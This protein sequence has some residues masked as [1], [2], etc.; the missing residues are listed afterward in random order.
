[1]RI[2]RNRAAAA[3]ATAFLATLALTACSAGTEAKSAGAADAPSSAA[4][5]PLNA[6]D[7]SKTLNSGQATGKTDADQ[8]SGPQIVANGESGNRTTGSGSGSR[9][10]TKTGTA[11]RTGTAAATGTRYTTCTGDNTKV[12]V[13]AVSRPINHLL[14]TATNAGSKNC[15]AYSAPL[16][17][18]DEDQAA[19][20]V[21][22]DSRP[23]AVV[24]LAP[25]ESAYASILLSSGDGS[26]SNGRTA[27]QL[28]VFFDSRD[29]QGSVGSAA[30]LTLPTDTYIDDSSAVSFWQSDLGDALTW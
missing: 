13:T 19:T 27:K 10:G 30:Q 24:T 8:G 14:L 22:Q 2:V 21:I 28:G 12:T 29:G 9:S 4:S 7:A 11:A 17:R 6:S 16:L 15:D 18:F 20:Q 3:A 1:M 5:V 25:G 23:Q 26:G